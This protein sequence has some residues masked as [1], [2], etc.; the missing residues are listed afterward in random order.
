MIKLSKLLLVALLMVGTSL[1]AA[2][3]SNGGGIKKAGGKL[4]HN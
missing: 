3:K 4:A 2:S 1:F